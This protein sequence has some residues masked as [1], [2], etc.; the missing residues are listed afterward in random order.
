[1]SPQHIGGLHPSYRMKP[2]LFLRP[3]C[4][5]RGHV[6]NYHVPERE[7]LTKDNIKV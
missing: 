3:H 7:P 1:M 6:L 4:P 2:A 5:N